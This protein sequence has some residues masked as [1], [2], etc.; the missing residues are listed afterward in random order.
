MDK[1][2]RGTYKSERKNRANKLT[3][4]TVDPVS[5]IENILKWHESKYLLPWIFH[6][7]FGRR[8]ELQRKDNCRRVQFTIVV[9]EQ[10]QT[11]QRKGKVISDAVQGFVFISE[12]SLKNE[13][14][15]STFDAYITTLFILLI[16]VMRE[17][18]DR[19]VTV[20]YLWISWIDLQF[21]LWQS[22]R[23]SLEDQEQ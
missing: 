1:Q 12:L 8:R 2:H 10:S 18:R 23:N 17:S 20:V 11:S 14:R 15:E 22:F 21:F 16:W 5:M 6:E 9:E 4:G 19:L 13:M 3:R 7:E